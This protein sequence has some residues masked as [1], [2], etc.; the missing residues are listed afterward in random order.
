MSGNNSVEPVM[1][2]PTTLDLC[3]SNE[4]DEANGANH[5]A[6]VKSNV[7]QAPPSTTSFDQF[8]NIAA[9]HRSKLGTSID[10]ISRFRSTYHTDLVDASALLNA[11][12][13]KYGK[14]VASLVSSKITELQ[15]SNSNP[16]SSYIITKAIKIAKSLDAL[17][18]NKNWTEENE[19]ECNYANLDLKTTLVPASQCKAIQKSYSN[20]GINGVSSK[21]T[22][23]AKHAI[24]GWLDTFKVSGKELFSCVRSGLCAA[25][26]IKSKNDRQN[27]FDARLDENIAMALQKKSKSINLELEKS[28][29]SRLEDLPGSNKNPITINLLDVGLVS[30]GWFYS[31]ENKMKK[32]Q[33][34]ML[35]AANNNPRQVS[36]TDKKGEVKQIWV[37]PSIVS[38]N[39]GVQ[40]GDGILESK[41]DKMRT[42]L[43]TDSLC[44]KAKAYIAEGGPGCDLNVNEKKV[45]GDLVKQCKELTTGGKYRGENGGDYYALPARLA[46]LADKIGMVP[47]IH[48]KSGKDRTARLIEESKFLAFQIHQNLES[49][50]RAASG[51]NETPSSSPTVEIPLVPNYGALDSKQKEILAQIVMHSG[52]QKIQEL[53]TGV[54]GNKQGWQLGKRLGVYG[55]AGF[56]PNSELR[57]VY[58]KYT[59]GSSSV[60][61]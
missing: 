40:R 23:N 26:K 15:A 29:N 36:Y 35:D 8:Q 42:K 60:S 6:V 61:S 4:V 51:N 53:N 59:G 52:N 55:L 20:D 28:T 1:Q 2:L 30:N 50:S 38:L 24:N 39:V 14:Q 17:N 21:D 47:M 46:L 9:K 7:N 32:E 49:V 5:P 11:I 37:K 44:N 43:A 19:F 58:E 18:K 13:K 12:E 25:V 56:N 54:V 27:A 41:V 48:C 10:T 16:I 33:F 3:E 45:I 34:K 31:S 57:K 22:K